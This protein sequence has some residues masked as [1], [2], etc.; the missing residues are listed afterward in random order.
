MA[1]K[2][3]APWWVYLASRIELA[4]INDSIPGVPTPFDQTG[5]AQ[6]LSCTLSALSRITGMARYELQ[7]YERLGLLGKADT[8]GLTSRRKYGRE[9]LCNLERLIFLEF[10][11][12]SAKRFADS[13]EGRDLIS[14]LQCQHDVLVKSA[15]G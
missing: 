7:R 9:T 10:L 5:A 6:K 2:A 14:E 3:I 12:A 4:S 15:S 1:F 8:S 13:Q 11:G